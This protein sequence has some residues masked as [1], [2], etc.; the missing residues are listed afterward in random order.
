LQIINKGVASSRSL[1]LPGCRFADLLLGCLPCSP[2]L[3]W[4]MCYW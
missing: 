2:G 1:L 3:G 4:L